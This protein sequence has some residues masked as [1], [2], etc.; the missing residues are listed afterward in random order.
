M[1]NEKILKLALERREASQDFDSE[2]RDEA[3]D[4]LKFITGKNQWSETDKAAREL[5]GR[6]CLTINAMPQ[7]V[8]QVTGQIRSMNPAIKISA[9][10]GNA[11]KEI[12]EIYEGLARDIEAR[13]DAQSVYEAAGESAATCGMGAFRIRA[14]YV[15]PFSFDQ[16]ILIERIPN[17]FSV[18]WDPFARKPDRC[19]AEWVMICQTM[20]R[21]DFTAEYPKAKADDVTTENNPQLNSWFSKE[22]VTVAEYFWK[23]YA[24]KTI[25]QL[26]NGQVTDVDPQDATLRSRK[27]RVYKVMWAKISG[28]EVLE[29]PQEFPSK[30]LPVVAVTGEEIHV[31]DNVYRTSVIRFAKDP[32]RLYNYSRS[33]HAE[34]TAL[35]P[36]APY[37]LTPKQ[38]AGLETLWSQANSG[39]LPFLLYN[40]DE[41]AQSPT[42]IQPPVPA[43]GLLQEIQLAGEDLKRTTGI[44]D[45]SLGNRSNETSGVAINARKEE[46]QNGTSI[47]ADNVV[48]AVAQCGRII[49]DMIPRIYDTE[50]TIR[51]LGEDD[52]EKLV[53]INQVMINNDQLIVNNDMTVGEYGVRIGVGPTYST[54]RQESADG[55]LAFVQAVP[56]AG[57]VTGD[58]IAK[59]QDWPD[60]ERFADRLRKTL[61]PGMAEDDDQPDP[62]QQQAMAMQQ[63]QQA[64]QMQMAQQMEQ[65]QLRQEVA[66]AEKAEA[67]A[68]KAKAEAVKAEIEAGAAL[69][70]PAQPMLGQPMVQY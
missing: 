6:P 39:A 40:P 8:R 28:S 68:A 7:F 48:K 42:R 67:D 36:K 32:Q 35:Q 38:V 43:A 54:R 59:A 31:G 34:V 33:T 41:K 24:D 26:P 66:K 30:F 65:I 50:R 64:Q 27:T 12:A 58:L 52:Q 62:A 46:S 69:Q 61:P 5:S 14:D 44:Y 15:S 60:A 1:D 2:N 13:S 63:Q 49:V 37:M 16:H 10:D 56:Q 29:G 20:D 70:Q 51:I 53:L 4:D 55:M 18:F 11:K 21:E 17:P 47:Y 57:A 23:E 25:W 3:L 19:D 9:A 22:T 45:A